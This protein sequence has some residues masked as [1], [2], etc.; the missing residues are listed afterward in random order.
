MS[1]PNS[2]NRTKKKLTTGRILT[3]AG[4]LATGGAADAPEYLDAPVNGSPPPP[5]DPDP[6]D[7]WEPEATYLDAPV[8]GSTYCD[9]PEGAAAEPEPADT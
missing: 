2:S 8:N 6:D 3:A 5:Y 1:D 9:P 7:G 4:V